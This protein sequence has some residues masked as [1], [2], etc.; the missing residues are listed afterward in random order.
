MEAEIETR[1]NTKVKS[2][3]PVKDQSC[4]NNKHIH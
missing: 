4:L 1:L 3:N 2:Q